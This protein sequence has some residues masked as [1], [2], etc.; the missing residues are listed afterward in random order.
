MQDVA[1]LDV[2]VREPERLREGER[3]HALEADLGHF[4]RL[5][6]RV[7][8]AELF[9]RA[10]LDE[11]HH[12]V[13]VLVLHHRVV[14]LHDVRV[15]EL[16]G[17]RGLVEEHALVHRAVLGVLQRLRERDLHRHLA[18]GEGILGEVYLAGGA[19]AQLAQQLVLADRLHRRAHAIASPKLAPVTMATLLFNLIRA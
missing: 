17:E 6:E 10:A 3:P 15:V 18:L 1:G 9:Q 12:D 4:A 7:G 8:L 13:A 14:D 19:A 2:A 16:A 11:L 5:E